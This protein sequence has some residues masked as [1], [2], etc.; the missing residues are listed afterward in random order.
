MW[1]GLKISVVHP[2][3]CVRIYILLACGCESGRI[4]LEVDRTNE[5]NPDVDCNCDPYPR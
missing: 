1:G 3:L 2:K 4:H 5:E